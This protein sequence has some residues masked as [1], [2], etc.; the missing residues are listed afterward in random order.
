MKLKANK[1]CRKILKKYKPIP[2]ICNLLKIAKGYK[3]NYEI[4]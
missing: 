1:R 3:L 2:E 4:H